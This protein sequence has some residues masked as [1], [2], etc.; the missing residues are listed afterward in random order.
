MKW[1]AASNISRDIGMSVQQ[2]ALTPLFGGFRSATHPDGLVIP[3]WG[4]TEPHRV[5]LKAEPVP[6]SQLEQ[7]MELLWLGRPRSRR[8]G[9]PSHTISPWL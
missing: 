3:T 4:Q 6:E 9:R 2:M 5:V 8:E 1:L 7:G